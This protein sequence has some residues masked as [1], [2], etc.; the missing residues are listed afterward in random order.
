MHMQKIP[1]NTDWIDLLPSNVNCG[2]LGKISK[3]LM[4]V[5]HFSASFA[6]GFGS[7]IG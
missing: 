5:P 6:V 2:L 7:F 1:P 4:N 3:L